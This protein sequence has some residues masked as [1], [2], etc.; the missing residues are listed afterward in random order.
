MI[1]NGKIADTKADINSAS[2]S[3]NNIYKNTKKI[4]EFELPSIN[5][6]LLANNDRNSII[7]A[8]NALTS[9]GGLTISDIPGYSEARTKALQDLASCLNNLDSNEFGIITQ[10]N[11]KYIIYFIL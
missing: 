10:I 1:M 4:N 8:V 11:I 6:N 9:I 3:V 2:L 5:F 7:T